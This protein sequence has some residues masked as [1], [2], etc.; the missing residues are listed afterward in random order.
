[1]RYYYILTCIF[2]ATPIFAQDYY[3]PAEWSESEY[4]LVNWGDLVYED[5]PVE[6]RTSLILNA[7]EEEKNA[8][9][10]LIKVLAEYIDVIVLDTLNGNVLEVL[11]ENEVDVDRVQ[12]I[13][14]T[15]PASMWTRDYGPF[16]IYDENGNREIVRLG[17]FRT[18]TGVAFDEQLKKVTDLLDSPTKL[19][20]EG[21]VRIS[22]DGG[23]VIS[24]GKGRVFIDERNIRTELNDSELEKILRDSL[25]IKEFIRVPTAAY[26][27]DYYM[28]L[29]NE[30]TFLVSRIQATDFDAQFGL[31]GYN[32]GIENAV[33][34]IREN[35]K[36]PKGNEYKFVYIENP[37]TVDI[38][39]KNF[40]SV[41]SDLT[42]INS[43][44]VNDV[45]IVPQFGVNKELDSLALDTYEKV[46]PGYNI[47]GV[48]F[49]PWTARGGVIHCVT[50][51]IGTASPLL[52]NDN[53]PEFVETNKIKFSTDLVYSSEEVIDGVFLYYRMKGE[54]QFENVPLVEQGLKRFE[55]ILENPGIG[56]LEY[57]FDVFMNEG[58]NKVR[59]PRFGGI[60]PYN[61]EITNSTSVLD[62]EHDVVKNIGLGN[63]PNPF[64]PETNLTVELPKS[65]KIKI[66]LY[67]LIGAK[68]KTVYDGFAFQGSSI[69]K[70]DS[71]GLST[72]L[73]IVRMQ[74]DFGDKS[75]LIS[76]IK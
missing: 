19:L 40:T 1:M 64:N 21:D 58:S 68:I 23:N 49:L 11:T 8:T 73:Y 34:F 44:I 74:T 60:S 9:I 12:V 28:K 18:L 56:T 62:E 53:V 46:M 57:F 4:V 5:F 30:E 42:Y 10:N 48:D 13:E 75:L 22:L 61:F 25:G 36:T 2:F 51:E 33:N 65:S 52:L 14:S 17:Y 15:T 3:F 43:L 70:I 72:G 35:F 76:F 27:I 6:L 24:D 26:H 71:Q 39:D 50:R 16:T 37:E 67:S 7:R 69:Y 63:Y 45:V 31:S 32:E 55:V 54:G 41:A 66:E 47:I 29:V 20:N 59:F 38:P